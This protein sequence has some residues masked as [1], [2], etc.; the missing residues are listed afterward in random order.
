MWS[1]AAQRRPSTEDRLVP[2]PRWRIVTP[3]ETQRHPLS[4]V[5]SLRV[6][7]ASATGLHPFFLGTGWLA[8]PQLVITAAHVTDIHAAWRTVAQPQSWHVEVVSGL[9]AGS[10]PLGE[11]WAVAVVCHPLWDGAAASDYDIAAL[12]LDKPVL[13]AEECLRP[14]PAVERSGPPSLVRVVGY[15]HVID[16]GGT[17]VE[18][19][20]PVKVVEGSRFFYD[21]DTEDGQSGAPVFLPVSAPGNTTV[22]GIH[23]GGRGNGTSPLANSLNAGLHLRRELI[24]WIQQLAT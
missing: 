5:A 18:G 21:I 9:A 3:A 14:S 19:E 23:C 15:P 1:D 22:V 13:P 24:D 6:H 12:R 16:K 20:G 17:P 2:Q 8:G 4:A 7:I 11:S 10:R